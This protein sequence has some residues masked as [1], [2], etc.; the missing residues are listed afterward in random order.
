MA[1]RFM[2]EPAGHRVPDDAF[3]TAR[4]TPRIRLAD[5]ALDHS[6]IGFE[7]LPDGFKAEVVE[8]AERGEA[9]R[10]EGSVEHVEVFRTVSVRTSI[11]EDLDTSPAI[12]TRPRPTL[13]TAMS[14]LCGL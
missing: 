3:G 13:S 8:T 6:S 9:G 14:R 12:A 2:R 1:E 7:T 4:A 10:S 11:L 5:T